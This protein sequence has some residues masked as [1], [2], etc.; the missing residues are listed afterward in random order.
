ML[1]WRRRQWRMLNRLSP[2]SRCRATSTTT[3]IYISA[4][5]SSANMSG[6]A[7]ILAFNPICSA[8]SFGSSNES[9]AIVE[10]F[11][12]EEEEAGRGD[13]AVQRHAD[14]KPTTS[15]LPKSVSPRPPPTPLS[16]NLLCPP[17]ASTPL[18]YF[19]HHTNLR[20][21]SKSSS[22]PPDPSLLS[23]TSSITYALHHVQIDVDSILSSS[24]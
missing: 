7:L 6:I 13:R 11:G 16:S 12:T 24:F 9:Q 8:T 1:S 15:T 14:Q 20:F 23:S 22:S 4:R 21:A 2:L 17:S 18:V 10:I 3:F 5:I 19:N